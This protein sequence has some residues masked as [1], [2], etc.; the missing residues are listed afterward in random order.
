LGD[1]DLKGLEVLEGLLHLGPHVA[2]TDTI[3]SDGARELTGD[4]NDLAGAAHRHDVRI[5]RQAFHLPY[6]HSLGLKPLEFKDHFTLPACIKTIV[7]A[8]RTKPYSSTDPP[9]LTGRNIGTA[10]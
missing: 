8:Y 6:V 3:S 5:G 2:L 7:R 10:T 4:A 1:V 9:P